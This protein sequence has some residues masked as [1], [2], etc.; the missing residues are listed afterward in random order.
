[1]MIAIM[2]GHLTRIRLGLRLA[3]FVCCGAARGSS[4]ITTSELPTASGTARSAR[5]TSTGFGAPA[6]LD[7]FD[8]LR[9][10]LECWV[11]MF[12]SPRTGG[13]GACPE[14]CRRSVPP[15]IVFEIWANVIKISGGNRLPSI[16]GYR[17]DSSGAPCHGEFELNLFGG[18]CKVRFVCSK[19]TSNSR[20]MSGQEKA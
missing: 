1:M 12:W 5:T 13:V 14:Q 17:H 19:P 20:G 2:I 16:T 4:A 18:I 3:P 9:A 10:G 15:Q 8:K 7:P 6:R 11:L